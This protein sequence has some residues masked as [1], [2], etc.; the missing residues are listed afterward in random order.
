MEMV[1]EVGLRKK[2]KEVSNKLM[3]KTSNNLKKIL[4]IRELIK[5]KNFL[6]P[7][8]TGIDLFNMIRN[9]MN[10]QK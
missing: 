3:R 5:E 8:I 6:K 2:K 1:R 4:K 9:I 10:E 7:L